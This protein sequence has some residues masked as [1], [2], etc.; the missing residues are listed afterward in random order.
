[1]RPLKLRELLA[2]TAMPLQNFRALRHRD[3]LALAFGRSNA[4]ASLT[5]FEVD[6][7]GMVLADAL[8]TSHGRN[9]TARLIRCDCDRWCETAAMV[10]S[11]WQP[12][13][14]AVADYRGIDGKLAHLTAAT[15][16]GDIATIAATPAAQPQTAGFAPIKIDTTAPITPVLTVVNRLR[17]GAMM[18]WL[19][20]EKAARNRRAA[21]SGLN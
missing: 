8:A 18:G 9:T 11:T 3:H 4:Y 12:A 5:F 19:R 7:L 21:R 14:Y 10:E 15:N 20:N 6:A 13:Y 16:T 17:A 1:M 2:V